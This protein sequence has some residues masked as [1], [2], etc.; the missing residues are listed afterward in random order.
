MEDLKHRVLQGNQDAFKEWMDV[1]I[2]SIE[3]FSI[4][5][6]VTLKEA[7][8]VAETVFR[9]LYHSLEDLT[10]DQ[11]EENTLYKSVLNEL[12]GLQIDHSVEDLF[13]F[14]E[15]NELH[16]HVTRLSPE[17][18][19]PLILYNFHDKSIPD[20]AVILEQSEEQVENSLKEAQ[21]LLDEPNLE[22]KLGFL[23]KSYHRLTPSYDEKHI[24]ILES[25]EQIS[26]SPVQ[27][28]KTKVNSGKPFLLWGTGVVLLIGLLFISVIRSE[29]YQYSTSE[30]FIEELKVSFEQKIDERYT[31]LG[32]NKPKENTVYHALDLFGDERAFARQIGNLNEQL[33]K[34]GKI[35]KKSAKQDYQKLLDESR[36]PSEMIEA[37]RNNPLTE[38]REKSHEFMNEL[39]RKVEQLS[40]SYMEVIYNTYEEIILSADLN[41]NGVVDKDLFLKKIDDYPIDLQ[42]VIKGMENQS[43]FL[44]G[45]AD[46]VLIYPQFGTPATLEILN[47][48]LHPDVN[49]YVYL[50]AGESLGVMYGSGTMEEKMDALNYIEKELPKTTKNDA[51]HDV[52][53]SRYSWLVYSILG[54]FQYPGIYDDNHSIRQE[55]R[56]DWKAF[57]SMDDSSPSVQIMQEVV[58][59]LEESDWKPTNYDIESHISL[60]LGEKVEEIWSVKR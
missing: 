58:T 44:G 54:I 42:N 22:K 13:P 3:R 11:L 53:Y 5:Y 16:R 21:T 49:V 34:A 1:Y 20:I 2:R 14:E 45:I 12:E 4:S 15:D 8:R 52:L 9:N 30:K 39:T 43:F 7:G 38:D 25:P 55:I 10:D 24:Y 56:E 59:E 31:L 27:E 18:R 33:E 50:L 37:L 32:L 40:N 19:V 17:I 41:A 60:L 36:L 51:L 28:P 6:G 23:N 29:A 48:N 46:V 35:D 57:A 47:Q 26:S